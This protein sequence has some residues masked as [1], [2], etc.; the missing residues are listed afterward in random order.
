MQYLLFQCLDISLLLIDIVYVINMSICSSK[1]RIN[2]TTN[3]SILLNYY[4]LLAVICLCDYKEFVKAD[5]QTNTNGK[6]A[7][8]SENLKE[9]KYANKR[10]TNSA[11]ATKQ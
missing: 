1:V 10:I 5:V 6:Q 11:L 7:N 2:I 9:N 4:E 3:I 8:H